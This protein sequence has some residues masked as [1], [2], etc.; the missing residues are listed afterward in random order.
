MKALNKHLVI[1]FDKTIC[2]AISGYSN[3][4]FSVKKEILGDEWGD[5]KQKQHY[6]NKSFSVK[7]ELN[8]GVGENSF[9]QG[10]QKYCFW[11]KDGRGALV[12]ISFLEERK[13]NVIADILFAINDFSRLT[14]SNSQ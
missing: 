13:E 8:E 4:S 10:E 5:L 14:N 3:S 9:I 1:D 2:R 11:S 12:N 6:S 7:K